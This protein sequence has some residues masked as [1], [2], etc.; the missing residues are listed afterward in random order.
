[1]LS[2]TMLVSAES[3]NN[4]NNKYGRDEGETVDINQPFLIKHYNKTM[5][6]VDRIDQN[7]DRDRTA[8]C[9]KKSS[10]PIFAFIAW[11]VAFSKPL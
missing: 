7:V 8:I 3:N 2:P 9:S 10:W 11:I 6:G 1:M 4:N 5:G